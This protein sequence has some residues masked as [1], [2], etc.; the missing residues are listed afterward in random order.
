MGWIGD[1]GAEAKSQGAYGA[2]LH[3]VMAVLARL[4]TLR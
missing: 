1:R 4:L 3:G 2:A